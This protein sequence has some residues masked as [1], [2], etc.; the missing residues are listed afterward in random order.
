MSSIVLSTCEVVLSIPVAQG[1][2]IAG[3]SAA[4]RG[5]SWDSTP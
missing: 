2:D 5:R 1:V 3:V 4:S